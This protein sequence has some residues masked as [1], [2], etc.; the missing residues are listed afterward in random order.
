M[1]AGPKCGRDRYDFEWQYSRRRVVRQRSVA[2][3]GAAFASTCRATC[4]VRTYEQ[5][6]NTIWDS[7]ECWEH[8]WPTGKAPKHSDGPAALPGLTGDIAIRIA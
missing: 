1:D 3:S 5:S 6:H 2:C 8:Q 7:T 4:V